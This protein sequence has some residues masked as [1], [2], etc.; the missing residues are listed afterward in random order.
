[1]P[2]PATVR[3]R[4]LRKTKAQLVD[5]IETLEQRATAIE[6]ANRGS[7][8]MRV[9]RSDAL[10]SAYGYKQTFSRPKSMS[11]LPPKADIPRL[12]LDFRL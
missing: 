9:C 1:M 2:N 8:P 3:E 11:A 4:R 7:A 10:T 12:T 6:A 5:E